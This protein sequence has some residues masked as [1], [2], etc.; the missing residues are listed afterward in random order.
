MKK[1]KPILLSILM[2]FTL[3][4]VPYRAEAAVS[5]DTADN[6]TITYFDDGSYMITT[7]EDEPG[8]KTPSGI[9]PFAA[10]TTVSKSKTARYYNS[11]GS[12]MWYL[13][14]TGSF[15][16]TGSSAKCNSASVTAEAIGSTWKVSK[17]SAAHSGATAYAS[18][19]GKQYIMGTVVNTMNKTISLTCS[20]TGI[21]S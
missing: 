1:I 19:T 10:S 11:E 16:Y 6:S 18:A 21:F 3:L 15:T 5:G 9:Q 20:P 2:L 8:S 14:V 13:K 17:L 4:A 7:I 12:V